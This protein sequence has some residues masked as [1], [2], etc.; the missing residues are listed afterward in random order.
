MLKD[1][2][3]L[4]A[5][6]KKVRNQALRDLRL[7][8]LRKEEGALDTLRSLDR[9]FLVR[10]KQNKDYVI[11]ILKGL[12]DIS[13]EVA[14]EAT[15][16]L[17]SGI[18]KDCAD[19]NSLK[20]LDRIC[21]LYPP[22]AEKITS[23]LIERIPEEANEEVMK[24]LRT[25]AGINSFH[26][27]ELEKIVPLLIDILEKDD[28]YIRLNC[29]K[30]LKRVD[31]Q[32]SEFSEKILEA[33]EIIIDGDEEIG[34]R[35][36]AVTS[37]H[38]I[39]LSS[40][41]SNFREKILNILTVATRNRYP[42]IRKTVLET[43]VSGSHYL[44]K[45][46]IKPLI[47]LL[48]DPDGSIVHISLNTL[49]KL[50]SVYPEF[51]E[52]L[53]HN[54]K[55]S[56]HENRGLR[57]NS[58]KATGALSCEEFQ[59][60]TELLI[61]ILENEYEDK[62]LRMASAE[63][64]I[65]FSGLP[66]GFYE[67]LQETLEFI[68]YEDED[69]DLKRKAIEIILRMGRSSGEIELCERI[70]DFLIDIIDSKYLELRKEALEA[71]G[72]IISYNCYYSRAED[73]LECLIDIIEEPSAIDLLYIFYA[74]NPV[75]LNKLIPLLADALE[76]KNDD[77]F[78][79]I[80]AIPGK[81]YL[82]HNIRF[83][84]VTF[85]GDESHSHVTDELINTFYSLISD[86]DNELSAG[87]VIV[88]GKCCVNN[89]K[90]A[91]KL[92]SFFIED[93]IESIDNDDIVDC[94]V[95]I[96]RQ[97]QS[98]FPDLSRNTLYALINIIKATPF[99]NCHKAF[100][101]VEEILSLSPLLKTEVIN[102]L[103]ERIGNTDCI[104]EASAL[105]SALL[106]ILTAGEPLEE[107]SAKKTMDFLFQMI[108]KDYYP[109]FDEGFER[110][111]EVLEY[112][113][114][115]YPSLSEDCIK[116]LALAM[117]FSDGTYYYENIMKAFENLSIKY[118]YT[119]EASARY[120][121][122][123]LLTGKE[124]LNDEFLKVFKTICSTKTDLQ[125]K[126]FIIEPFEKTLR[127]KNPCARLKSIQVLASII[128]MLEAEHLSKLSDFI[129]SAMEDENRDVFKYSLTLL[130]KVLSLKPLSLEEKYIK[131]L[132]RSVEDSDPSVSLN[133]MEIL[134]NQTG[135]LSFEYLKDLSEILIAFSEHEN[136]D[137]FK[138]SIDL[139]TQVLSLK[140]ELIEEKYITAFEKLL[141]NPDGE[142]RIMGLAALDALVMAIP[143]ELPTTLTALIRGF[144][145][146]E[147]RDIRKNSLSIYGKI[148]FRH[149]ELAEEK[150]IEILKK[151]LYDGNRG[152]RAM[153]IFAF[154]HIIPLI[155]A[156]LSQSILFTIKEGI[157][158]ENKD[159][160]KAGLH[161]L[162]GVFSLTPGI[163]EE[164]HILE[165][166]RGIFKD[167]LCY[168]DIF[169][170]IAETVLK[171]HSLRPEFPE[172]ILKDLADCSKPFIITEKRIKALDKL[173]RVRISHRIIGKIKNPALGNRV[174]KVKKHFKKRITQQAVIDRFRGLGFNEK[175]ISEILKVTEAGMSINKI[176]MLKSLA[177]KKFYREELVN[178]LKE[179]DFKDEEITFLLKH[180]SF[181]NSRHICSI[182]DSISLSFRE[183]RKTI[184][185]L[186]ELSSS[187]Y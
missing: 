45:K 110:T 186:L 132:M 37:L 113:C 139:L 136:R 7:S 41:R 174:K 67:T 165:I 69:M 106:N 74:E 86:Y 133:S 105:S 10:S 57:I 101:T 16:L 156:H 116:K 163:I 55:D 24:S 32:E 159:V 91:G 5:S 108:E 36:E 176:D 26:C 13:S 62:A 6:N 8:L 128:D 123:E 168:A 92:L 30:L 185:D 42:Q 157:R 64:L 79:E 63:A 75:I 111:L 20:V 117:K 172:V 144:L 154:S 124:P 95:Q 82:S 71:L 146:D 126:E 180:P 169:D 78:H 97:I 138:S 19:E 33:F 70:V 56:G 178:S 83:E 103:I 130:S 28:E 17:F 149:P 34:V 76:N 120:I 93:E 141:K 60:F 155:P 135:F 118:D 182:A 147:N 140:P 21:S 109:E 49:R 27:R 12:I 31:F 158:Y 77:L 166:F 2:N 99:Y 90:A 81:F 39:Y 50:Y 148:L 89:F 4:L 61:N 102:N 187:V 52:D 175:E 25:L 87:S 96:L 23:Y 94:I 80:L 98:N 125:G 68:I 112:F 53:I 59:K 38:E 122:N 40:P 107:E 54:I 137:V 143:Y 181:H 183:K 48:G 131:L 121:L 15:T 85:S 29:I 177:N 84:N 35:K 145:E 119:A 167:P 142:I 150:S 153:A 184:R 88:L 104:H 47:S 151:A 1:L 179:M 152:V 58:I 9:V 18:Y 134:S 161:F 65:N 11:K 171:L 72:G 73:I 170:F 115:K 14:E 160:C 100:N 22:L 44:S 173:T 164:R 3:N 129:K 46:L 127:D 66:A 43:L 162:T 51:T 114:E